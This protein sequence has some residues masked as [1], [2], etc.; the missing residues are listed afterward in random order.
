VLSFHTIPIENAPMVNRWA[1]AGW[2]LR[3]QQRRQLRPLAVGQFMAPD[4][5]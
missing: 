1:A 2:F 4:H 3:R 5:L